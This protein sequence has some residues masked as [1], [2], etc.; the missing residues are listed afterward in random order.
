MVDP[1]LHGKRMGGDRFGN[2]ERQ[3]P[4]GQWREADLGYYGG[5]RSAQRLV[6]HPMV[7][8]LSLPTITGPL[9]RYPNADNPMR[10]Q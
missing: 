7:C 6:F 8:A 2:R 10:A 9:Y 3:L 5:R 4:D 1:F